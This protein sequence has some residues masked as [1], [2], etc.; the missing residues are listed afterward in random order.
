MK[1]SLAYLKRGFI[2]EETFRSDPVG[3]RTQDLL[4]RRQLLYPAELPDRKIGC[5]GRHFFAIYQKLNRK[6]YVCAVI[7]RIIACYESFC[8]LKFANIQ[9]V[10]L[11]LLCQALLALLER[12]AEEG[13]AIGGEHQLH[14]FE[15]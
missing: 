9:W 5:K 1:K 8:G 6:S 12:R 11:S 15:A 7:E 3:T 4:L 2:Y 14:R 10:V 13:V